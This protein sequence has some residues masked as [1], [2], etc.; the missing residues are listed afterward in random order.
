MS[1][2]KE[3]IFE[4]P[5]KSRLLYEIGFWW[6]LVVWLPVYLLPFILPLKT[7]IIVFVL[8]KIHVLV[9]EGCVFTRIQQKM[10]ILPSGLDYYSAVFARIF[11]YPLSHRQSYYISELTDMYFLTVLIISK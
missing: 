4:S 9:F 7:G 1:K 10:G 8:Y 3:I 11:K 2:E 5:I 6:H